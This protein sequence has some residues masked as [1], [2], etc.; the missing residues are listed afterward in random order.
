VVFTLSNDSASVIVDSTHGGRL[1]SLRIH[2]A[3]VL[4]TDGPDDTTLTWGCYPM[5]P[6]AGRVRSGVVRFNNIE[7][8]LPLTLP[9]HAGHGTVF[10]QSWTVLDATASS[11]DLIADLGSQWPF[12]GSVT[13]RIE[14]RNDH[15]PLR[16]APYCWRSSNARTSWLASMV[17]QTK[18][19]FTDF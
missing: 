14:L 19:H 3:E 6:Y 16:P 2:D 11:L 13:Q 1:A 18:S 12:G 7:Y 5:V 4:L 15:C 10:A 8:Q 17:L 9:P